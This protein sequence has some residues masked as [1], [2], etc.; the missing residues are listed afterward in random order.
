MKQ[1]VLGILT[2]QGL[3]SQAQKSDVLFLFADDQWQPEYTLKKYFG[4]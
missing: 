4:K 3:S 2:L 1:I